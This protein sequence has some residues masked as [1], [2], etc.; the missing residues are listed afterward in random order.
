M[1]ARDEWSVLHAIATGVSLGNTDEINRVLYV[2]TNRGLI[3]VMGSRPEISDLGRLTLQK[4]VEDAL[5]VGYNWL[6]KSA[7]KDHDGPT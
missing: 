6:A 4:V 2:L 5:D 1:I 7:A 3:G